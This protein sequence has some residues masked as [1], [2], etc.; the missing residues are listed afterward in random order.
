LGECRP[1]DFAIWINGFTGAHKSSIAAVALSF[2]GDF[3]GK[4]FP[5]NGSDTAY[6]LMTKLYQA[7]DTL[8]V[9]DEFKAAGGP[10]EKN[11]MTALVDHLVM[12][13]GNC[14]GRSRLN[15]DATLKQSPWNRSMTIFTAEDVFGSQSTL[16]RLLI[17]TMAKDD[18]D[19]DILTN[20]QSVAH[21]FPSVT[22]AYIKW[23][24]QRM[25][26]LKVDYPK[27]VTQSS[28]VAANAGFAKSHPRASEIYG[29][30]ITGLYVFFDF[31][32][33]AGAIS[34]EMANVLI[35]D[36][37]TALQQ[38]FL[39]QG[40]YQTDQDEVERFLQLLRAV[41][42]SGNGHISCRLNMGPPPTRPYSKGWRDSGTDA[43]GD[44]ILKPMGDCLGYF[45]EETESD[46]AEF[47]L[48]QESTFKAIQTFARSQGDALSISLTTLWRRLH[49]KGYIK[50]VEP[51]KGRSLP[52]LTVKRIV[53]GQSVR[54]MVLPASLFEA[55][56]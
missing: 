21:L 39:D 36:A 5:G 42:S 34:S 43:I 53:A 12:S 40:A 8:F 46:T 3:I 56:D 35:G 2:F 41:L 20:L 14:S 49:E 28:R 6:A 17:L 47:W 25:D 55:G 45:C 27:M 23:L 18:V 54:V 37:E 51:H 16:A 22:S 38:A 29:N 32:E 24:I 9:A 7:K 15:A 26:R 11:K 4:D 31:L 48:D 33:D 44:K 1:S 13:T 50:K 19:L 52:R 10:I 30:L